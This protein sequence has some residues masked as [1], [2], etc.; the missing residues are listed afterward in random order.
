M[1]W[2]APRQDP[3]EDQDRR[4]DL[5]TQLD[6][7][8]DLYVL[9]D[10]TKPRYIMR[11]QALKEELQRL[12]PPTDPDLDSAQALLGDFARFWQTE[13]NPAERRKLIA[14]PFDRARQENGR[15]VAVK[16]R[17]AFGPYFKAASEAKTTPAKTSRKRG[18]TNTR[19]SRLGVCRGFG[20]CSAVGPRVKRVLTTLVWFSRRDAV[21][22]PGV[23]S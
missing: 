6:R 21:R 18:V 14:S 22:F 9:G 17:P 3:S 4:R 23:R 20:V 1:L 15:I 10:L 12:S 11:R 8:Q 5:L 13:T 19:S 16:P 7:L 2:G